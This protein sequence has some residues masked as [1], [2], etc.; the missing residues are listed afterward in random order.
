MI[1][2]IIKICAMILG[3]VIT[4]VT[5]VKLITHRI[6]ALEK[7][8]EKHNNVIERVFKLEGCV[9]EIQKEIHRE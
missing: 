6:N 1:D 4:I 5:N 3:N 7:K 2:L 9:S 8:V